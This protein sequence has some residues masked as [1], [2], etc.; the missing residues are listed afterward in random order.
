MS[1]RE[2]MRKYLIDF[3]FF[4]LGNITGQL[5]LKAIG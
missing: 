4:L 3:V 2:K 1:D 5:I